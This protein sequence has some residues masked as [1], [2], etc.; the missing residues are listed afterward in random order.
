M[1]TSTSVTIG[2]FALKTLSVEIRLVATTVN[3]ILASKDIFAQTPTSAL[4]PIVVMRVLHVRIVMVV[5][6]ALVI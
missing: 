6:R 5:S 1:L 4:L 3:V 2:E